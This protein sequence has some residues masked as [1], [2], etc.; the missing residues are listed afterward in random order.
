MTLGAP[1]FLTIGPLTGDRKD[2]SVDRV[3]GV[4][5]PPSFP[6]VMLSAAYWC[7]TVLTWQVAELSLHS[8]IV[9]MTQL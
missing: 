9:G 1:Y 7:G 8:S 2:G 3:G 5:A 6:F 4:V